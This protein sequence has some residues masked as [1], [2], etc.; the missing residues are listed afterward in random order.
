MASEIVKYLLILFIFCSSLLLSFFINKFIIKIEKKK[1]VH[2]QIH[3]LIVSTHKKKNNTPTLGGIAIFLSIVL[4]TAIFNFD[5]FQSKK[6]I[7]ITIL[8]ATYFFVGLVDDLKK[9]KDKNEKG[10][11]PLVR[12]GFEIAFAL[13]GL[14]VLGYEQK[15]SWIINFPFD[16]GYINLSF[17]VPI[18]LIFI[19]VGSANASN[20]VDG[21]D[22]LSA[23]ITTIALSPFIF[24]SYFKGDFMLMAFLITVIGSLL[25]FLLLNIYPANIFMGDCGSLMLGAIL[26][27]MAI[28]LYRI[29]ELAIIAGIYVIECMSVI[30][31]V[32]YYKAFKKRVFLMAPL[33]HHFELKGWG[34][35]KVVMFYYLIGVLFAVFGTII[36][37]RI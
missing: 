30:I 22:G 31:Q 32:S 9:L 29:P 3:R 19:I 26:G 36:G 2:Q 1:N 28:C 34:E 7:F 21:L 24:F 27:S 13:C 6:G 25:G 12:I 20:L 15:T 4:I 18:F 8:F 17:L 14:L 23:G 33:H 11:S 16:I 37:L 10:L 35:T 5:F